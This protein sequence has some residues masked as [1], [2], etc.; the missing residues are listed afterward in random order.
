[1]DSNFLI[2]VT[3]LCIVPPPTINALKLVGVNTL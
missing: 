2:L 3:N 1:M